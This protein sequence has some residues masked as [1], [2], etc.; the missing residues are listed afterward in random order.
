MKFWRSNEKLAGLSVGALYGDL[1]CQIVVLLY[2]IERGSS[3]LV[4][5]PAAAGIAVAA[6]KCQRAS[7]FRISKNSERGYRIVAA[8]IRDE[9]SAEG[10][11][12]DRL[13][14]LTVEMDVTAA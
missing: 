2:L 1:L 6:W 14:E 8:R 10:A 4:T 13:S 7:G 9:S 12:Y 11:R 3:L 5:G